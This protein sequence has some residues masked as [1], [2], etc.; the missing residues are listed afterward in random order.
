MIKD[1]FVYLCDMMVTF[2]ATVTPG[3][4]IDRL[5]PACD[6]SGTGRLW[7]E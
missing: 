6:V 7:E 5:R 2:S 1:S 4:H 3:G